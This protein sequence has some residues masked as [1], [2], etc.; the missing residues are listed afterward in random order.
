MK[1]RNILVVYRKELKDSLRDRR[2][3]IS[4][5]AVPILLMP[6]L[7]IGVGALSAIF[8]GRAMQETPSVMI[9]G[10]ADSPRLAA[11]L[12]NFSDVRLVPFAANYA[13]QI[14]NKRIRAAAEIPKGF[15]AALNR[16]ETADIRIYMYEGELRS[17]FAA[18]R[19][20]DFFRGYRERILRERLEAR[21]L[22]S[23]LL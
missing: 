13:E 1:A 20:Q 11:A 21:N 4:M 9:I 23:N 5:I 14:T 12:H 19:L 18:S 6:L 17:G 22:P 3:I 7:T 2:T 16:G 10:G 15:D 8:F